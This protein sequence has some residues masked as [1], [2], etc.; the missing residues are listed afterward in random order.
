MASHIGVLYDPKYNRKT[1]EEAIRTAAAEGFRS[2]P[3]Q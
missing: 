1:V 2:T 3:L